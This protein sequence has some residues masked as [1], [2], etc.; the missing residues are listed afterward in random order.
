MAMSTPGVDSGLLFLGA[1]AFPLA[2]GLL[3]GVS[4]CAAMCGPIH[5][6][7]ARSGGRGLWAYHVGRVLTYGGLGV[8][9]GLL[10]SSVRIPGAGWLWVALYLIFGLR[11]A[12]LPLWPKAWG[13]RYGGWMSMKLRPLM[14]RA[15]SGNPSV[16]F[17]FGLAAGLLPCA[18]TGAGMAWAAGT[19]N[20]VM[21]G[22]GMML[23]GTGT[24]PLFLAWP[25]KWFP[26]GAWYHVALG[27]GLI[28]L[29]AVKIN[30]L[31]FTPV[32]PGQ[33]PSCH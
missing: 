19:A 7:L 16:L 8:L 15:S 32:L 31:A 24:L 2:A 10:A 18:T 27:V 29:A 17:P 5:L 13:V 4:H 25:R 3:S 26:R 11:L 14:S 21:G 28:V 23:L 33:V 6:Y 12:G 1:F 9:A 22:A 20:P 30:A